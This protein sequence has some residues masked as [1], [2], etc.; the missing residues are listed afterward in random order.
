M[1]P[2]PDLPTEKR[3]A[4]TPIVPPYLSLSLS[5]SR[6]RISSLPSLCLNPQSKNPHIL[7]SSNQKYHTILPSSPSNHTS[8]LRKMTP[9]SALIRPNLTQADLLRAGKTKILTCLTDGTCS[10]KQ[11]EKTSP[12]DKTAL[13]TF[14]PS[15]PQPRRPQR[16]PC[17]MAL[18]L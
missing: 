8:Y 9:T 12:R 15:F 1:N 5:L 4:V 16:Q 6:S 17:A 2:T 10:A 7:R 11:K 18:A 13:L 14:L 3:S